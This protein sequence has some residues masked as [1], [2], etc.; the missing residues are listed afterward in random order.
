M[1]RTTDFGSACHL[2]AVWRFWA[3]LEAES[4]SSIFVESFQARLVSRLLLLIFDE[5]LVA[6]GQEVLM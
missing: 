2:I 5:V 1:Q 3:A 4:H 6:E